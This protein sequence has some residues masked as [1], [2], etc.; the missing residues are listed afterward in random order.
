MQIVTLKPEHFVLYKK[1]KMGI[2]V[3]PHE[4]DDTSTLIVSNGD[5]FIKIEKKET[6]Q[7]N[8]KYIQKY[9]LEND[10]LRY[11]A[12]EYNLIEIHDRDDESYMEYYSSY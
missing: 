1:N 9:L 12:L 6:E 4:Y 5:T 10:G 8:D 7:P 2:I 11:V 3:L